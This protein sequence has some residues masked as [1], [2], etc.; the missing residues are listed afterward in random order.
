MCEIPFLGRRGTMVVGALVTSMS[1]EGN[2]TQ[3]LPTVSRA[4]ADNSSDIFLCLHSSSHGRSKPWLQLRHFILPEYLL[5]DI[6]CRWC[7]SCVVVTRTNLFLPQAYTPEVLPSAHRA[8]GN[9]IAVGFN[10][11]MGIISAIV[12]VVADTST[13]VPIF[14]CA[15]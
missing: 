13:P 10:R 11:V 12:G 3:A 9:G 7:R 4:F 8:T 6:I 15:A 1:A 5:R 14:I 2:L